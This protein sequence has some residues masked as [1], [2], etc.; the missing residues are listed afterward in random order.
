M[1]RDSYFVILR[2]AATAF[3][4]QAV[5]AVLAYGLQIVLARWMGLVEFGN[6]TYAYN[7][8]QL[9]AV[10]GAFGVTLSVLR[11]LP[12][13][14]ESEQWNLVKGLMSSF[15]FT[16]VIASCI[17]AMVF[18]VIFRLLPQPGI[19][20]I[21]LVFGLLLV[22]L[23]ALKDL[24][25]ESIRGLNRIA[26]AYLPPYILQPIFVVSAAFFIWI[27]SGS[28]SALQG[29]GAMALS[30]LLVGLFQLIV[31][32]RNLMKTTAVKAAFRFEE[33]S[34]VSGSMLV[35]MGATVAWSR[36]DVLVVG[37]LLGAV[38]VG[39]YSIAARTAFLITFIATAVNAVVAQRIAPLYERGDRRGLQNLVAR[40][41]WISAGS[42]LVAAVAIIVFSKP[43]LS[44]F[45]EEFLS[46][47]TVLAILTLA[48]MI[49]TATG[50]LGYLL[51]LTG[52]QD[53]S[54]RVFLGVA[55]LSVVL[56]LALV[57][58]WGV[59]G[60]GIAAIIVSVSLGLVTYILVRRLV[61]V[62]IFG[63]AAVKDQ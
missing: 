52:H 22:P 44:V 11:F 3:G 10:F 8:A 21:V 19:N 25:A 9:L 12:N 56:N 48:Q 5:G 31:L 38:E 61:G 50:P 2:G 14:V 15:R 13:Y 51:H 27:G 32:N 30:L 37:W 1:K 63:L 24:H 55:L 45:G 57:T 28:L 26:L 60:A 23:I 40:A 7:W 34:R 59:I 62:D 43:L 29:I 39:A 47:Q 20:G 41:T 53:T 33:W 42:A 35:I 54:A 18:F 16:T 46:A 6:Y 58:L 49:N 36:I 4:I 17:L